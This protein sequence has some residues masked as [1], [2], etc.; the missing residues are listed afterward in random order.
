MLAEEGLKRCK[1]LARTIV[2]EMDGGGKHSIRGPRL[3]FVDVAAAWVLRRTVATSS[4][5]PTGGIDDGS[6]NKEKWNVDQST[7]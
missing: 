1:A 4:E 2:D 5:T 6:D 3:I 7:L